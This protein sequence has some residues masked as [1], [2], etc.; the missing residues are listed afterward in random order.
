MVLKQEDL[1]E[2][3][4]PAV[5]NNYLVKALTRQLAS[6]KELKQKAYNYPLIALILSSCGSNTSN[7][8]ETTTADNTS[9]VPITSNSVVV[10]AKVENLGL[11][12]VND[13]ITATSSTFISSTSVVDKD[14]YDND[15]IT[16]TAT[17]DIIGTATVSGLENIKFTTSATKLGGDYEFDVNLVNI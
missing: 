11:A 4:S 15:T 14:P 5:K 13:T 9:T 12:G 6:A 17:D 7:T 3:M 16:I 1:K 2:K 8:V 10:V